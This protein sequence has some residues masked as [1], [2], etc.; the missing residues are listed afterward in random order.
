MGQMASIPIKTA[1]P[2][3]LQRLVF[4]QYRIEVPVMRH[5]AYTFLRYS[6]NGFNTGQDLDQ[7]YAAL[8]HIMATTDFIST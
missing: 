1:Q 2:E 8:Q 3:R 6:I 4:E 7:L 5:D